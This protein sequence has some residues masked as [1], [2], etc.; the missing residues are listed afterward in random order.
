MLT[1][2]GLFIW[3]LIVTSSTF[4]WG[5]KI[6]IDPGHGGGDSGAIGAYYTEKEANL[7]VA[8]SCSEWLNPVEGV[9]T[10][11]TRDGDVTLS[12]AQ[13][14]EY[15]NSSGFD[16]FLSI[17][18][19]AYDG[20]VQ[21][22]ES[23]RHTTQSI[24]STA[25][26]FQQAIHPWIIW[27]FSYYDRGMKQAD[28]YVLRNTTMPAVLA[29]ASFID[30]DGE[31]NESWRFQ[32]NWNDHIGR[33]GYGFAAGICDHLGLTIAEYDT[34]GTGGDTDSL[35]IDDGDPEWSRIGSWAES[36]SGGWEEDYH[37][38]ATTY[39]GDYAEYRPSLPRDG[40]WDVYIWYRSGTNRAE[41]ARVIIYGGYDRNEVI[42]NQRTNGERWN[43]L[44]TYSF[45]AT[46]GYV[47]ITDD[48][49]VSSNV[50]VADA[51]MWVFSSAMD[52]PKTTSKPQNFWL[53]QNYPNPFNEQTTI[54]F[55]LSNDGEITFSIFNIMGQYIWGI[56]NR[57][58]DAGEHSITWDGRN[59]FEQRVPSGVY[60]GQMLK[61]REQKRIRM[62]FSR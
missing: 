24:T 36:L 28:F 3:L 44:G 61:G 23:F 11:L 22:S 47:R 33:E 46:G 12:L 43:Y 6:C 8:L 60:L 20:S 18:H 48:G 57:Y 38:T 15:A 1:I 62:I 29:E 13:R 21:G 5:W 37:W 16:R 59:K 54:P 2:K 49:C 53:G 50:V 41:D 14:C 34:G 19:N 55:R 42:V 31:Y 30:Y 32:T 25:G 39:Q 35:I 52:A 40:N 27:A 4:L 26:Q 10:G 17:H 58:Y 9:N 56:E 51:V 45:D 7:D